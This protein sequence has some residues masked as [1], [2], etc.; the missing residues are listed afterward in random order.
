MKTPFRA[1]ANTTLTKYLLPAYASAQGLKHPSRSIYYRFLKEA[2]NCLPRNRS[3]STAS[4]P[5]NVLKPDLYTEKAWESIQKLPQ[6]AESLEH[7][8][9][10]P[11]VLLISLLDE[12]S[13]GL[14][15]RILV[16]AGVS[17]EGALFFVEEL[18]L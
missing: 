1:L 11:E 8:Y 16:K 9:V 13:G 7:Q 12:G 10:E 17:I 2:P 18:C 15:H 6:Y 14:T 4:T 5:E 3:Y